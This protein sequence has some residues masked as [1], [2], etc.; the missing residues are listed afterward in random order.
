MC[1][2]PKPH[3]NAGIRLPGWR[4]PVAAISCA[5]LMAT[6]MIPSAHAALFQHLTATDPASISKSASNVVS[7]WADQSGNANHASAGTGSVTYPAANP[8]PTGTVGVQ[9][10]PTSNS[11]QLLDVA[12]TASL[13]DFNGAAS[14]HSGFSVLMSVRVDQINPSTEPNDLIG[15]TSVNNA[16]GFGLRYN[17]AGQIVIYMGGVVV[18]RP[19]ADRKVA[20]GDTVVFAVNYDAAAGVLTLWDSLN[21]TEVTASIPKGNFA[22]SSLPLKLG[23]INNASRY[24][25]GSVGEVRIHDGMLSPTAF[26]NDRTAMKDRWVKRPMQ[27]LDATVA[28]SVIGNPVTQW[29]DQSGNANHAS[30]GTGSVSYPSTNHVSNGRGRGAIRAPGEIAPAFE[31]GEHGGLAGFQRRGLHAHGFLGSHVREGRST[32]CKR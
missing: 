15:V 20:A 28:G 11:L 18:Q 21:G 25:L 7:A 26:S 17:S 1:I 9:F 30:A 27:S 13:L 16:G 29:T 2:K 3:G 32:A 8:F 14:T 22:G 6:G 12:D 31:R 10:G 19:G 23:S 4:S 5:W 24:L